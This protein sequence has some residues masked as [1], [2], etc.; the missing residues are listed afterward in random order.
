MEQEKNA[1]YAP[2]RNEGVPI[3]AHHGRPIV[4]S[5]PPKN[6]AI[7]GAKPMFVERYPSQAKNRIPAP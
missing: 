2:A 4:L 5:I 7:L 1:K 3:P 6:E